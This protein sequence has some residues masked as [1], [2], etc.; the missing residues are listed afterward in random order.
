[1][2]C[3]AGYK[4]TQDYEWQQGRFSLFSLCGEWLDGRGVAALGRLGEDELPQE[5]EQGQQSTG[6][7]QIV[8]VLILWSE[9]GRT[10]SGFP[11]VFPPP[12]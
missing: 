1:M 4:L 5:D 2:Y 9:R 6:P 12:H 10:G 3:S 7:Q 11:E 8:G